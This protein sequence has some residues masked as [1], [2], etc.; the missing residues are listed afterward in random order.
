MELIVTAFDKYGVEFDK[1]QY[2]FMN[3]EMEI[4]MTGPVRRNGLVITHHP[5][6]DKRKF[7]AEGA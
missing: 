7:I 5:S 1:D 3:F 2:Q 6:G 4:E